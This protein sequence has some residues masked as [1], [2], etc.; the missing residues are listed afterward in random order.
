MPS[1]RIVLL[2]NGWELQVCTVP[3][4]ASF[5]WQKANIPTPPKP[6]R[7]MVEI[8][9]PLDGH[10]EVVPA[11]PDS[12]EWDAWIEQMKMWQ[13]DSDALFEEHYQEQMDF[14]LDYAIVGW[15]RAGEQEWTTDP[16]VDW[17]PRDV[18][19]RHGVDLYDNT[20]LN[21][22]YL[23]LLDDPDTFKKSV[24]RIMSTAYPGGEKDTSS[25]KDEEVTAVLDKFPVRDGTPGSARNVGSDTRTTKERSADVV[26]RAGDDGGRGK[27]SFARRVVQLFTRK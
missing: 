27:A 5:R 21:F 24:S 12:A 4:H 13:A 17:K 2:G 8:T 25:V 3:P 22:I 20:R 26:I 6:V 1:T 19:A 10:T 9:S 15:R 14:S 7:P 16:P 11:L 23:E 18:L